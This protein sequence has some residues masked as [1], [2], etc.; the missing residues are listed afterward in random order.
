MEVGHR[1]QRTR[2]GVTDGFPRYGRGWRGKVASENNH[3]EA[4][5]NNPGVMIRVR[6]RIRPVVDARGYGIRTLSTS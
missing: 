5:P 2:I 1:R 3:G 4:S 6:R